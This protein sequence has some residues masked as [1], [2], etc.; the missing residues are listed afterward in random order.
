MS[1]VKEVTTPTTPSLVAYDERYDVFLV[2]KKKNRLLVVDKDRCKGCGNC[3]EICPYD[4]LVIGDQKTPRGYF[5]PNE[6]GK[7][8]A[9]KQCVYMCPDFALSLYKVEELT[10]KE[11]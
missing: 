7:C 11:E 5:Y 6:I 9:C 1:N 8:V 4:A 2:G 10:S 3:V